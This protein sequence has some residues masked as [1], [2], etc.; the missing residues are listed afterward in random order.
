MWLPG[1]RSD[2]SLVSLVEIKPFF[3]S[4]AHLKTEACGRDLQT[5]LQRGCK[6]AEHGGSNRANFPLPLVKPEPVF[7]EMQ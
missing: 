6:G 4:S 7:P 3:G 5:A 1:G 2:G